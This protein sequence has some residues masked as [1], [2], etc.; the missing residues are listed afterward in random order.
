MERNCQL[1]FVVFKCEVTRSLPKK[2]LLDLQ[3][4]KGRNVFIT[5]NY[6]LNNRNT[7]IRRHFQVTCAILKRFPIKHL[8]WC[9][10]SCNLYSNITKKC[11]LLLYEKLE[12][13]LCHKQNE[14]LFKRSELLCMYPHAN[15]F[16]LKNNFGNDF[17]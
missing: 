16:L 12:I 8:K 3:R 5:I 11:I 10:F 15:K 13:V 14:L 6:H 9:T 1:Y 4:E 17:K 2:R 7:P